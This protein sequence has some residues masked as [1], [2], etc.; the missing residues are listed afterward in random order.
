MELDKTTIGLSLILAVVVAMLVFS[1]S[2]P[3]S[4][5]DAVQNVTVSRNTSA[6][7]I[8]AQ[9]G[10]TGTAISYWNFTGVSGATVAD[11]QNSNSEAQDP[12]AD[13]HGICALNNTNSQQ[14]V[15]SVYQ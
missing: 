4:G 13:Q 3:V 1:A 11:P 7:A 8:V 12:A 15:R 5:S 2:L 9:N 14:I 6:V 10:D